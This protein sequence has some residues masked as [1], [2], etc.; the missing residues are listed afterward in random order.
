M[1]CY[2]MCTISPLCPQGK[3]VAVEIKSLP[4]GTV[5]FEDVGVEIRRGKIQKTLRGP[6]G[7]R[8]TEPLAGQI[9]YETVKG[10]IDIQFGDK[11]CNVFY[12]CTYLSR[13]ITH[14]TVKIW[15][16]HCLL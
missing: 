10:P 9:T 6:L 8:I 1:A 15:I 14:K 11:V 5:V 2:E 13:H 7:Q 3:E 12:G 16:Y 4:V